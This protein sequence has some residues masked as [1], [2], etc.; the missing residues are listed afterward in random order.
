MDLHSP[1]VG[2]PPAPHNQLRL[3]QVTLCAVTSVN[4][5]ATLRAMEACIAQVAFADC[6]LLTDAPVRAPHP[7]IRVVQIDR[8]NSSAAYSNFL[9]FDLVAYIET[10]HCL[11]VQWD[12]HLIDAQRWRSQFLDYDYI[13]AGWPQFDDGHDVGNGG[14]SLRSRRLMKACREPGFHSIHP[15]DVAIGRLNRDWLEERSMRFPPRALADLFSAERAGDVDT[16]FGYHG[17]F[18]MPRAVGVDAFWTIYHELD[19]RATIKRDF[20][21]LLWSVARSRHGVRRAIRMIADRLRTV[22]RK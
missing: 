7:D 4:V 11:V 19:N 3:P 15:E 2:P 21:A 5:A 16:A 12:G 1:R 10:S 9:L 22:R 18:N 17:V 8:I 20:R 14:F 6:L 13:G